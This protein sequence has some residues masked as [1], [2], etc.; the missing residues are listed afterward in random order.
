MR[1]IQVCRTPGLVLEMNP[2]KVHQHLVNEQETQTGTQSSEDNLS[3]SMNDAAQNPAVK[4]EMMRRASLLQTMSEM[5][6]NAIYGSRQDLPFGIRFVKRFCKMHAQIP[7]PFPIRGDMSP[8]QVSHSI[9][10]GE[11]FVEEIF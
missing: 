11:C 4:Q 9:Y 10:E 1:H 3:V 8:T 5:V 2:I 7:W 6:L